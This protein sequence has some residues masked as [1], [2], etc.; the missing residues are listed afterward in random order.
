LVNN[1]FGT[2]FIE[3]TCRGVASRKVGAVNPE[4]GRALFYHELHKLHEFHKYPWH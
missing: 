3:W 4:R 1:R 2:L